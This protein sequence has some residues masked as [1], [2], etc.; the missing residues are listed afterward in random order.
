MARKRSSKIREKIRQRAEQREMQG[1]G[2]LTLPE[3]VEYF[4]P[5]KGRNKFDILYYRVTSDAHPE[6]DAGDEWYQRTFFIHRNVGADE[7]SVVCPRKTFGLPCPIC[8]HRVSMERDA[9]AD[10][11]EI[12]SLK[13]KERELFNV[14]NYD[15]DEFQVMNIS[16]H[17]FGKLLEEEIREGDEE[18]ADFADPEIGKTIMARF[19]EKTWSGRKFYEAS[20]IDFKDRS[21]QY[22]ASI[23]DD[24]VDLDS[25][26]NVMEYDD[27]YNLFWELDGPQSS[28]ADDED[29]KP[30]PKKR[31]TKKRAT[32][33]AAPKTRTRKKKV[34]EPEEPEDDVEPEEAEDDAEPEDDYEDDDS[35]AVEDDDGAEEYPAA[36]CPA[37]Y[38]FG[39]DCNAY[40]ECDEC[41][42]WEACQDEQERLADGGDEPEP[43]PAPKKRAARKKAA[44]KKAATRRAPAKKAAPK[45]AARGRR[46]A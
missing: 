2:Y 21:E 38:V 4:N 26:I 44:P 33:K 1:G 22:D 46:R 13:P 25:C 5:E 23:I 39:V 41:E 10:E 6:V 11:D 29:E 30:A 28:K 3:G 14:Y 40:D 15:A 17:L 36:E 42:I 7:Q 19:K 9:D 35:G 27:L 20:R 24:M 31:A 16:Y 37:D 32:K 34:E 12:K 8:E 45:K 43:E 18:D